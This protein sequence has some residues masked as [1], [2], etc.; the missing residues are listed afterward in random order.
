MTDAESLP[1]SEATWQRLFVA[2]QR[3][4]QLAPWR[5]MFDTDLFGVIAPDTGEIGY[6]S[7]LGHEQPV[8]GLAMYRGVAG[9]LN[10]EKLQAAEFNDPVQNPAPDQDCLML[11]YVSTGDL[12]SEDVAQLRKD[13]FVLNGQVVTPMF[14]DY[15]PGRLPAAIP[16]EEQAQWLIHALEQAEEVATALQANGD[17]LDHVEQG[18][19][20]LLVRQA[21]A[22]PAGTLS[23]ETVWLPLTSPRPEPQPVVANKLYLR[24]NCRD[25]PRREVSWLADVFYFPNPTQKEG[26]DFSPFFPLVVLLADL[27][28]GQV[29]GHTLYRPGEILTQLQ[30]FWV[31]TT[32][33]AGYLPA[34]LVMA[35]E[36]TLAWWHA[37]SEALPLRAQIEPN[38]TL[39]D[40]IRDS[41][42][43]SLSL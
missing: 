29:I 7:V 24:S 25:L 13:G 4:L 26:E 9:L 20:T 22:G 19:A 34:A 28:S 11:R 23:W 42:F 32:K 21:Q 6:C 38:L 14:I 18:Q 2:A 27:D 12:V 43:D 36:S 39:R 5:W 30:F 17:L 10:Y 37:I 1:L 41:L 35:D 31:E 16:Q 40:E 15:Q 3:F 8:P 33:A